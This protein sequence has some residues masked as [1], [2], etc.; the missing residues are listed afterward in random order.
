MKTLF[1]ILTI[2]TTA[3]F[4]DPIDQRDRDM[5]VSHLHA[6][7]KAF[8]DSI[9]GLSEAQWNYKPDATTWSVAECAEHIAVSEDTLFQLVTE[10]IMKSPAMPGKKAE[11]KDKDEFVIT[12]LHDRSHKAQA[13]EFL[14]P[15]HRWPNEQVLAEHFKESR[16]RT[17]AYV[18]TTQDDLRS[19]FFE[20]PVLKLLDGYQWILLIAAHSERHTAQ[21]LEVKGLAGFPKQ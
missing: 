18:R 4:A 6:S 11:V 10:K 2:A 9:A 1:L 13:P 20:H 19:H 3:A 16:D 17:I 8:L 12:A 15:T 5:A 7:R 21:I 14:R